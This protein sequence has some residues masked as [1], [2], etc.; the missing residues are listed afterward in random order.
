MTSERKEPVCR[1][2]S[3]NREFIDNTFRWIQ[4]PALRRDFLMRG[5]PTHEG[6]VEYFARIMDDPKQKVFAILHEDVH[7]GNCGLKNIVVGKEAELWI[8]LGDDRHKG[9]GIAISATRELMQFA[10]QKLNVELLYLHVAEFNRPAIR[11]YQRLGFD[12]VPSIPS[13]EWTE[14]DVSVLRMEL[15][16]AI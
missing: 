15:E 1:L 13:D 5:D 9:R 2:V 8:Y 6:H 4:D 11:L 16:K 7:V 3:M 12:E 10:F 14:R